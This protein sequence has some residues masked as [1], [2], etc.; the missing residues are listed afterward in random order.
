MLHGRLGTGPGSNCVKLLPSPRGDSDK[1][2]VISLYD[3]VLAKVELRIGAQVGMDERHPTMWNEQ[4]GRTVVSQLRL[5]KPPV[6][7]GLADLSSEPF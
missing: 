3:H 2:R 5:T 6:V 7:L 1:V 4:P